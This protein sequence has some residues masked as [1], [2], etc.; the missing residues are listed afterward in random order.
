MICAAAATAAGCSAAAPR[1]TAAPALATQD[2]SNL[3]NENERCKKKK[4]VNQ[5]L[6]KKG[7]NVHSLFLRQFADMNS[8]HVLSLL[9]LF[10]ESDR[11]FGRFL[12]FVFRICFVF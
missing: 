2:F 12:F 10:N 3:A 8:C 4:R 1:A 9:K 7:C 6:R 5:K 11:D